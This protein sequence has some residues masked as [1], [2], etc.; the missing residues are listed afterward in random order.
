MNTIERALKNSPI[1][2]AATIFTV[3]VSAALAVVG[4]ATPELWPL[5]A[6]IL[7]AVMMCMGGCYLAINRQPKRKASEAPF[8]MPNMILGIQIMLGKKRHSL[9]WMTA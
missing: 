8:G 5:I 3:G 4:I 7:L 6:Q 9:V 2:A 1:A